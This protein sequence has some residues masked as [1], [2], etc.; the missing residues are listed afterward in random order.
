MSPRRS[1]TP[2]RIRPRP[3]SPRPSASVSPGRDDAALA[4]APDG[5]PGGPRPRPPR[6]VPD[7]AEHRGRPRTR[8]S[9]CSSAP[10]RSIPPMPTRGTGSPRPGS[11]SPIPTWPRAQAVPPMRAAIDKALALDPTSA[12]AHALHGQPARHLPPRLRRRRAGVPA[13]D[14]AGQHHALRRRLRLGPA[15]ARPGRFR[16]G[17]GAP[18]PAAQPVFL[19]PDQ[20]GRGH[21]PA[22]GACWTAR[23]PPARRSAG[24]RPTAAMS[25]S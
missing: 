8:R 24:W 11:S 5:E 21:L 6:P 4:A 22:I 16:P 1:S 7:R 14:R 13:G 2:C 15:R 3:R 18:R 17:R 20:S 12:S 23:P 19:R 25:I 10:R 9:R